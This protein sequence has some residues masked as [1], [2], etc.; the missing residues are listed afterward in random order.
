MI[1]FYN[2]LVVLFKRLILVY[3][4]YFICRIL[5][6]LFNY[7]YFPNLTL[8]EIASVFFFGLRFDSFSIAFSNAL[9]IL[10]SILPFSFF[11]SKGYQNCLKFI[12]ILLNTIFILVNC[13]DLVYF[14]FI[15]KRSTVDIVY[16]TIGG[17]TDVLKQIPYYIKD[18][19]YVFIVGFALI[20]L[21]YKSYNRIKLYTK[22][23]TYLYSAK[24]III[25]SLFILFISG[26]T[27][28]GMRGGAK[29]V[30]IQLVD[31]GLY[32]KPQNVALVLNTPFTIMLTMD[33]SKIDELNFMPIDEAISNI[34]PI[35]KYTHQNFKSYNVVCL[36]LEG[37]SKE[38]TGIGNRKSYTPFLDSLMGKSLVFTNAWANGTKSIEGVAAILSSIPNL[39]DNPYINSS[40]CDNNL[41]SLASLLK[42]KGYTS[43]FF[44]GGM[45]GTMN[46]DAY[47]K[48]AGFDHYFGK[49]EYPNQADFDGNWGIWDEPYLK[50]VSKELEKTKQPFFSSIFTLSSHHPYKIPDNYSNKFPKGDLPVH[51]SIGYADY[52]LKQ[53]FTN[54]SKT[55]WYANTLFVI[56]PDHTGISADPFYANTVGQHSIPILFFN[57]NDTSL[58]GKNNT[59]IQQIDILPSVLDY[60]GYNE[61]FFSFG[62]SIFSASRKNYGLFYDSGNYYLT[63]DSLYFTFNNYETKEIYH[64]KN[65][66]ALVVNSV[67]K[68]EKQKEEALYYLKSF[69]QLYNYGLINNKTVAENFFRK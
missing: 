27:L 7:S 38:Y 2:Q 32:A 35:K 60:L 67:S 10:L 45:N 57:P 69:N 56:L 6:L 33:K 12:F 50:Y 13:I 11:Y 3:I 1:S 49:N 37:F 26:L 8:S 20:Y 24:S 52:A 59:T 51:E 15:K 21:F 42:T 47:S 4:I 16:Q 46:F 34:N 5:F 61:H 66:S 14:S 29:R 64:Y 19:W 65:D 22:N 25:Y 41:S 62:Q 43:S 54:A 58:V 55:N 31:A 44:H 39:L 48:T 63:D 68:F 9:F 30:P 17:Q 53:F 18:F 23:T 40:Y 36:I 28:L